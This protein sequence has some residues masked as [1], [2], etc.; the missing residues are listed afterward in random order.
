MHLLLLRTKKG[1]KHTVVVLRFA[2]AVQSLS[3]AQERDRPCGNKSESHHSPP[4]LKVTNTQQWH[5]D[6]LPWYNLYQERKREITRAE[7]NRNATTARLSYCWTDSIRDKLFA[8]LKSLI[9][10][11]VLKW[12][13]RIRTHITF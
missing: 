2:Y 5:G 8:I 6:W 1:C 3:R 7:K 4:G 12:L 11:F 13:T 10:L 9:I